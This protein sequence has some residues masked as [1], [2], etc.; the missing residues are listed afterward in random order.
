LE[1]S[2]DVDAI[3]TTAIKAIDG[4]I[5]ALSG[6]AAGEVTVAVGAPPS[7]T[8]LLPDGLALTQ[9][10]L[11]LLNKEIVRLRALI[12]IDT[13]NAKAF[14][15]LSEKISRDEAALA[16]RSPA[17]FPASTG[18]AVF[19]ASAPVRDL[20]EHPRAV[21]TASRD[22][23]LVGVGV[24]DEIGV[25]RHDNDLTAQLGSAKP[26]DQLVE[27]RLRIEVFLRLVD[28]ERPVVVAVDREVEEQE[29]D[30]ARARRELLDVDALIL[31]AV[32]DRDVLCAVEPA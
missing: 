9:N 26:P 10:T 29:D 20:W 5:K 16:K 25:M 12:G 14:S 8:S 31:D 11:S 24:D 4:R 3:L 1:F 27:D 28:D 6:P 30:A 2:G 32:A 17:T 13:E 22:N 21:R 7:A 23:H 15:R 18:S 19:E